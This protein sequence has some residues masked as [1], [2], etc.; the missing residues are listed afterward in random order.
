MRWSSQV[1]SWAATF[2]AARLLLP[3][4]YG[5]VAMA[6]LA[7]GLVRM[8][9]EFGLDAIL[10]QDRSIVGVE[11]A[12]L[13]GFILAL[14]T[15]LFLLFAML[16]QPIAWFFGEP[17]LQPI[18]VAL[19]LVFITDA[20]QVVP[21]AQL[22]RELAFARLSIAHFIQVIATQAAL[23]I[24]ASAGLGYWSL[25]V[26]TLTGAVVTTLLLVWWSPFAARW[27]SGL[28]TVLGPLVQGWRVLISRVA[29]YASTNADQAIIGKF[30]GKEMLGLYSFATTFST[31]T[32]QEIGAVVSKVVPSIFS[33]V[34]HRIDELRRYFLL[35]TELLALV[36]FPITVGL[37]WLADLFIALLLGPKWL[38][39]IV[40]LRLL[41]VYSLVMTSQLMLVH[42]LMWTGQFRANM[43]CSVISGVAMP[44]VLFVAV[45][46]GLEGIAWAWVLAYPI[47]NAPQFFFAFRTLRIRTR[48]WFGALWPALAG[49]LVMSAALVLVRSLVPAD[50]VGAGARFA[51][52]VTTGAIAY[53]AV[54]WFGFRP[55]LLRFF[56]L[57]RV[58]R[59]GHVAEVGTAHA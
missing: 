58:L 38:G 12:R 4:D 10:V 30:L 27:P 34:Q 5:L 11:L 19:G 39:V 59:R 44:V 13:A 14:G 25:V 2:Y 22:Q 53:L 6:M 23:V 31:I 16:S 28:R 37:A 36:S 49:C 8:V 35:L 57:V 51:A 32:Q 50:A 55:R 9:E 48:D 47:I 24:A 45:D 20:L 1:V 46:H 42:V 56:E 3:G 7:V 54:L 40:P 17:R 41:C 52:L 15:G 43:W 26:N 29:Y 33:E 21:R 18:V